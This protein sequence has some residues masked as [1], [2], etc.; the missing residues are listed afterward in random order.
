MAKSKTQS[1]EKSNSTPAKAKTPKAKPPEKKFKQAVIVI[2]GMGEQEP[3]TTLRSFVNAVWVTDRDLLDTKN[4]DR[5]NNPVWTK[6]DRRNRSF[7]LRRIATEYTDANKQKGGKEKRTD[8]YEFYWAH[9]MQGTQWEHL[10]IWLWDLLCRSPA[11]VPHNV[12]TAWLIL[13]A[14]TLIIISCAIYALLPVAS[15][16]TTNLTTWQVMKPVLFG[17]FSFLSAY[18]VNNFL[19]K[20]F[21][22]VAR[23]VKP[24]PMNVARRQEIRQKGVELLETLMGVHGKDPRLHKDTESWS[25]EYDRIIVVGHSLGSVVAYDILKHTFARWNRRVAASSQKNDQTHGKKMEDFLNKSLDDKIKETKAR[26]AR[27]DGTKMP[28]DVVDTFD[29]S[30]FRKLQSESRDELLKQGHPWIV[31]DFITLGSPLTHAEFLMASDKKDMRAQQQDRILPTCPPTL[32]RMNENS[33]GTFTYQKTV[34]PQKPGDKEEYYWVPHHAAL[35]GYTRWTNIYSPAS[36]I[37]WGD[38]ISGPVADHFDIKHKGETLKGIRDIAVLPKLDKDGWRKAK[39]PFFTHTKYWETSISDKPFHE[40][41]PIGT[42]RG[43]FGQLV[44]DEEEPQPRFLNP[45]PHHILEL[46]R[47]LDILD[48]D[49]GPTRDSS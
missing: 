11:R 37:A 44:K 48:H 38:L 26:A 31:S 27:D 40:T 49:P 14:I 39:T 12:F 47:A 46:R 20:Y 25:E 28:E 7:E 35:F 15:D 17:G 19:L 24:N 13:W 33:R 6:P 16:D 22:D 23:Y 43:I 32:E 41:A 30:E 2:H 36:N 8:F 45:A 5:K 4:D 10:Q 9:L 34:K 3:M 29:L 1:A 42:K 18:F 21:G